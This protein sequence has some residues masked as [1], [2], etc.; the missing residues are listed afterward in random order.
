MDTSYTYL[1]QFTPN[2]LAVIGFHGGPGTAELMQA[3]A[4]LAELNRTGGRK[5]PTR[6]WTA[7]S[8]PGTRITWPRPGRPATTPRTGTT[9]NCAY[10]SGCATGCSGD[11]HVPGSRR[12][13]DPGTYLFTSAQW[14]P[15]Q[16]EFCALVGKPADGRHAL[17]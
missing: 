12:Y 16:A 11:V 14:A 10:C 2:V 7:S 9:G 4:M 13:A 15:R 8:R 17:E 1:R 5:V 6:R 3:V